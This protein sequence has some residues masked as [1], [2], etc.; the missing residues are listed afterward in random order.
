MLG[1]NS[2]HRHMLVEDFVISEVVLWSLVWSHQSGLNLEEYASV[3]N[4]DVI[5]YSQDKPSLP[6]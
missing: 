1:A 5:D 2:H 4:T 3:M 6:R